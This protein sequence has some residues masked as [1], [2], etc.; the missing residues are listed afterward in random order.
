MRLSRPNRVIPL[1]AAALVTLAACAEP[2]DPGVGITKVEANLVFGVTEPPTTA[3]P[4]P[5]AAVVATAAPEALPDLLEAPL[6][7]L[8]LPDSPKLDLDTQPKS[9][10]PTAPPTAVVDKPTEVTITGDPLTG[11]ARWR[12]A[13]FV[14]TD[15]GARQ[16]V[17]FYQR[18]VVRNHKKVDADTFTFET[19]QPLGDLF[20]V[21]TYEVNTAAL[22]RNPTAGVG[23]VDSPSVGDPERGVTLSKIEYVDRA[24]Q[25]QRS[26][27]PSVGLLLLPLPV[28][29]GDTW[30]S[31]SVDPK[32]GET[33]ALN[34]KVMRRQRIDACGDLVDGWLVQGTQVGGSPNAEAPEAG[35]F[36]YEYVVATQFGGMLISERVTVGQGEAATLDLTMQLAQLKPDPLPTS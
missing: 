21:S 26:F 5:P 19:V 31:V 30:E 8:K 24:G 33:V 4:G 22:S 14:T 23:T 28:A 18:K 34:A 36:G 17:D 7:D 3:A 2:D 1:L 6:Q 25:A 20:A 13:G 32:S 12:W 29:A 10:C 11:I 9:A 35:Q 27:T 16:P 15:G